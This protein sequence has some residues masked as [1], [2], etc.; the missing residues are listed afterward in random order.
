M[1]Q[2]EDL[3]RKKLEREVQKRKK[4]EENFNQAL[5]EAQEKK[6]GM[7][8]PDLE[9][10]PHSTLNEDEFY[11]AVELGL[12]RLEEEQQFKERLKTMKVDT[13][14]LSPS[15]SQ[16]HPLWKEIN[17]V[18]M[19][20]LH[21]AKLGVGEGGWELFAED[22]EMRMYKREQEIDGRVVD[23]LKAVHT[24]K[25]VTGHE[26]CHYFFSADVRM[27]WESNSNCRFRIEHNFT[28]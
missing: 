4:L 22:G 9:E 7:G 23:P 10:G 11:D 21:Y 28:S 24:V 12:D 15:K 25:G 16:N 26:M 14:S 20:Q 17:R 8:G 13:S 6:V 2:R 1:Q 18:T 3:W 5:K 27:E 19:E